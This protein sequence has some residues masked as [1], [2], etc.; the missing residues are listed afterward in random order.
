MLQNKHN[1]VIIIKNWKNIKLFVPLLLG[2][3]CQF[4]LKE[5]HDI[6]C[7]PYAYNHTQENTIISL[8]IICMQKLP[9]SFLSIF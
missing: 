3:W 6:I 9:A 4:C 8:C 5:T 7:D 2:H 1:T